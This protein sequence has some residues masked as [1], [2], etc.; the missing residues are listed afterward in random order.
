[1]NAGGVLTSGQIVA[2]VTTCPP[3]PPVPLILGPAPPP[4]ASPATKAS[5]RAAPCIK[6]NPSDAQIAVSST[7]VAVTMESSMACT[8]KGNKQ[9]K[10]FNADLFNPLLLSLAP[11][12]KDNCNQKPYVACAQKQSDMRVLFDPY[13][14]RFWLLDGGV[15]YTADRDPKKARGYFLLAVSQTEDPKDGWYLYWWDAVAHR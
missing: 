15:I 12:G 10:L 8:T 4:N 6:G 7:H 2:S 3:P 11:G 5:W 1:M 9:E 14:K 13:P